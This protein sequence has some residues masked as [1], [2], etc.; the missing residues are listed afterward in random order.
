MTP[1]T[2]A[3]IVR[4][5][6][7]RLQRNKMITPG[8]HRKQQ[9]VKYCSCA[10]PFEQMQKVRLN[11]NKSALLFPVWNCE[12][13]SIIMIIGSLNQ[14]TFCKCEGSFMPS[15]SLYNLQDRNCSLLLPI[16]LEFKGWVFL[17]CLSNPIFIFCNC[18]FRAYL[19]LLSGVAS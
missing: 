11:V 18:I 6:I 7:Y 8:K 17:F 10:E 9:A 3:S 12:I 1:C 4:L 5:V 16:F 2:V 13:L 14:Y 19:T 15:I